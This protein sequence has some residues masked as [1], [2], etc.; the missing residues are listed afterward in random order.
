[1]DFTEVGPGDVLSKLIH[2]IKS[3][4]KP[5][6]AT[7]VEQ[8]LNKPEK[9]PITQSEPAK[10][11]T[12][13]QQ[14]DNWNRSHT[15]GTQVKAKG[16]DQPL[17]TKTPAVVLFGHRAAIYMQGYNGYFALD[18]IEPLEQSVSPA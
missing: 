10:S 5:S 13:Q 3:R 1:M 17:T 8:S 6:V 14:V 9:P 18:D 2:G 16:Y 7:T 12:P 11:L 15:T 4:F